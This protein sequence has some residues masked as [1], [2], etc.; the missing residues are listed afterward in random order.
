MSK[1]HQPKTVALGDSALLIQ[2]GDEI[3]LE[4]NRRVHAL[5]ARLNAKRIAG[6]IETVPAY[7]SL[8]VHY[9]PLSLTF[10]QV[11]DWVRSEMSASETLIAREPRRIEVP[12]RYGGEAGPDLDFVAAT[13][14]LSA[15]EVAR[16]HAS[17]EYIVYMMG[18]T[19]GF[20][21]MGKLDEA[22]ATPRLETP[23]IRVAA[24]SVGIA[25]AQTGIY[26]IDSPG[27]WRLIGR[28]TLQLFHPAAEP[29]FL[30][31]PGDTV[32]FVIEALDA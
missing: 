2:L 16:I 30:F 8:L 3:D 13:H 26:P 12:V 17:R 27:G 29:P 14:H 31:S 10:G 23:R 20:P 25:G 28:T 19:P 1:D 22:I 18:F 15:R 32:K 21:Y 6:V 5:D 4:I 11:S 9:D 24:G 7:A